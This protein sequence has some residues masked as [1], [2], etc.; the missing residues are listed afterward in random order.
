MEVTG[1]GGDSETAEFETVSD[2]LNIG[3][4]EK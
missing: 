3:N 4:I 1:T 2:S